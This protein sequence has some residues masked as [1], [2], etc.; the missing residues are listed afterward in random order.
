MPGLDELT[1]ER[2]AALREWQNIDFRVRQAENV[3]P[4]HLL[5]ILKGQSRF[6]WAEYESRAAKVAA[7]RILEVVKEGR[8]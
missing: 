5:P 1:A 7:R 8:T 4:D 2:D 3:G 6:L